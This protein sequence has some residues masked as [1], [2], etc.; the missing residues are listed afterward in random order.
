MARPDR[1][2]TL[3]YDDTLEVWRES[4]AAGD[5]YARRR[6][7]GGPRP[8][9]RGTRY[10]NRSVAIRDLARSGLEQA[11]VEVAG[12]RTCVATPETHSAKKR[13][14]NRVAA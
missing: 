4:D 10:Q 7:D 14:R 13:L 1:R 8:H 12:S 6:P 11:A 9:H 5:H 3:I 2:G